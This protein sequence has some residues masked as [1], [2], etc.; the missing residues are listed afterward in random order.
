MLWPAYV[1]T[2]P[3]HPVF[4]PYCDYHQD[5]DYEG[6]IY[7]GKNIQIYHSNVLEIL[8]N[9]NLAALGALANHIQYRTKGVFNTLI[10]APNKVSD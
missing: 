8:L 1:I 10:G 5:K 7:A 9:T 4:T 6:I 3:I 2:T